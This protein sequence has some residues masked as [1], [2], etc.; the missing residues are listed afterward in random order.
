MKRQVCRKGKASTSVSG[1]SFTNCAYL[2]PYS[3][4]LLNKPTETVR[5]YLK[6]LPN[7]HFHSFI[8]VSN[9]W[10]LP[11]GERASS[12]SVFASTLER[13]P[14]T[15]QLHALIKKKCNTQTHYPDSPKLSVWCRQGQQS[16]HSLQEALSADLPN[17]SHSLLYVHTSAVD[18]LNYISL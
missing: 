5:A 9:D 18:L 4:S 1:T 11:P 17:N 3:S 14:S 8:I 15:Q 16:H 2:C 12:G 13:C 6:H 7:S 10:H